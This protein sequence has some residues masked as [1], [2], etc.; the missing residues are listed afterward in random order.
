ML[1]KTLQTHHHTKTC[2]KSTKRSNAVCRFDFPRPICL[3]TKI[4]SKGDPGK[5]S[6][7][8]MTKRLA[9]EDRWINAYN[10]VLRKA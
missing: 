3:E 9:Q 1:V 10:P 8:F 7:M 6:R 2:Q 4:K 5:S